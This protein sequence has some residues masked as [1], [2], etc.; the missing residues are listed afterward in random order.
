[1]QAMEASLL[2]QEA[3][4]AQRDEEIESIKLIYTD[5]LVNVLNHPQDC[6]VEVKL[7]EAIDGETSRTVT[8]T[9]YL[10]V[11]YP[12]PGA[13]MPFFEV[14]GVNWS[15]PKHDQIHIYEGMQEV[16]RQQAGEV[17]LFSWC[18]W[19]KEELHLLPITHSTAA[20]EQ[21]EEQETSG[22]RD[23][24]DRALDGTR[25]DDG[26]LTPQ[27]AARQHGLD[28]VHGAPL[29]ERRSTFQAH[30]A[31]ITSERDARTVLECLKLDR[32]IQ[33]A[34]HNMYAFRVFDVQKQAQVNDNDDDGE[35][36]AGGKL[37]ELLA[38]MGVNNVIVVVSRWWGGLLLGPS[39]FR[40]INNTA[41]QLLEQCG[42]RGRSG[43]KEGG[44]AGGKG[45]SASGKR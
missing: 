23:K 31:R 34:T 43:E 2:E 33:R 32:K 12:S 29:T 6:V 20:D 44:G 36:A 39:R 13:E 17:V 14:R 28:L 21:V 18:E 3:I 37:A 10:P 16:F 41:R 38:V 26:A 22:E 27:Y 19:L 35:N 4:K 11:S 15:N 45:L 5:D 25:S 30:L 8:L 7:G 24:C 42:V 1:M 40:V 9:V